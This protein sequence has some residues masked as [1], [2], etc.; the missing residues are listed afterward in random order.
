MSLNGVHHQL[1][2]DLPF[3]LS[4]F[5]FTWTAYAHTGKNLPFYG[6]AFSAGS[7]IHL[8]SIR[9]IRLIRSF[10][11]SPR[12]GFISDCKSQWLQWLP[13]NDCRLCICEWQEEECTVLHE[14]ASE[15]VCCPP[16]WIGSWSCDQSPLSLPL[17]HPAPQHMYVLES[18]V[19]PQLDVP[20]GSLLLLLLQLG[21][22][23]EGGGL[24]NA[25]RTDTQLSWLSSAL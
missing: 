9:L 14:W 4:T 17:T 5:T 6:T 13:S 1:L 19:C 2:T 20:A 8:P 23:C 11:C 7:F 21:A 3:P 18:T 24:L 12:V 25:A 22:I 16:N 10:D 15:W